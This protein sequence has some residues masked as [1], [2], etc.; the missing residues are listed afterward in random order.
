[1]YY[2][3]KQNNN[4]LVCFFDKKKSDKSFEQVCSSFGF[5]IVFESEDSSVI[6]E[7]IKELSA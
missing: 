5:D 6:L 2:I 4:Y 1:M 7:K 3:V